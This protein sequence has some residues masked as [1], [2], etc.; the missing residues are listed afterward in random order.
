M[1]YKLVVITNNTS[2]GKE[3][4]N[5]NILKCNIC[6]TRLITIE[7]RDSADCSTLPLLI[8]EHVLMGAVAIANSPCSN[9]TCSLL[10]VS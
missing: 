7:V 1:Y 10:K 3:N 4:P 9:A 8:A 5:P 2:E 6:D